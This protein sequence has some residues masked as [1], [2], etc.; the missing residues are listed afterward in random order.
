M[1]L[2]VRG[3]Y[4]GEGFPGGA[5]EGFNAEFFGIDGRVRR[6]LAEAGEV[7]GGG[8]EESDGIGIADI[9]DAILAFHRS[10]LDHGANCGAETDAIL[11]FSAADVTFKGDDVRVG[12][13]ADG[14]GIPESLEGEFER[15][16]ALL[17]GGETGGDDIVHG[18]GEGLADVVDTAALV[19]DG[20]NGGIE[21]E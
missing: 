16:A 9:K 2:D 18:A 19:A 5:L 12:G 7:G 11:L 1:L 8:D 6:T 4:L 17:G 20:G 13:I 14:C 21:I 3:L 10:A 15:N